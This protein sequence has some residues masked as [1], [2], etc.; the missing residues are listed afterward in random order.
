MSKNR[1]EVHF[2]KVPSFQVYL[3]RSHWSTFRLCIGYCM[4]KAQVQYILQKLN[5]LQL[6]SLSECI[7]YNVKM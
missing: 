3:E 6:T 5:N 2:H 1:P 4:Y 7:Y